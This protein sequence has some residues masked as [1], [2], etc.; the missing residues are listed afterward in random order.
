MGNLRGVMCP[1]R[2]SSFRRARRVTMAIGASV[3]SS[4]QSTH[5]TS[6]RGGGGGGGG[7]PHAASGR[8]DDIRLRD[9]LRPRQRKCIRSNWVLDS[10]NAPERFS[11]CSAKRSPP[12]ANARTPRT[13]LAGYLDL[14]WKSGAVRKERYRTDGERLRCIEMCHLGDRESA[15]TR[16]GG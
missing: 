15:A 11:Y 14:R 13:E 1:A 8:L 3:G 7:S 9:R 12:W 16:G 2:L 5:V 10:A 4:A 6:Q